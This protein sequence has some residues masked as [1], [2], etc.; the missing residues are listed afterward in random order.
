M[1]ILTDIS[2][3]NQQQWESLVAASPTATW[4]QTY[5]A[6]SF[7]VSL[8]D[9]FTPFIVAVQRNQELGAKNQD[10]L[11]G[12]VVGYVTR[13]RNAVKQF[14][15]RR[16][17]IIGGPLL[18]EDITDAELEALL[19]AVRQIKDKGQKTKD[20]SPIYIEM[21]NFNDYSR[22]KDVFEA[23]G[24]AYQPHLNFHV[25]TS[26]V[27]VMEANL[28]KSRKR[29]LKASEKAGAGVVTNP[30]IE[31]VR[32]FYAILKDLYRTRVR[33]PL[34]PWEFFEKL[35]HLPSAHFLL[36]ERM[37]EIIGGSVGVSLYG[38]ALY[39]WFACGKDGEVKN[40]YPS[41]VTTYSCMCYAVEHGLPRFDMMGAG[42]PEE[43]YGVRDF[44]ARFGGELVEYGRY[45]CVCKPL[46]YKIGKLGVKLLK[47]H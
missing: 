11:V 31:Q 26:S 37:G 14:F 39:D 8:P 47:K 30:T 13:E 22:W 33:T 1:Q 21:R 2:Q 45:L 35:Y 3:I 43:A 34:F 15:T 32:A 6:Y 44:K 36:V 17:I 23:C 25:D 40:V 29:D 9:I 24:F 20:S 46:L 12:V 5:E 16:A 28:H 4:F 38:K 18:A 7:Y 42:K 19:R 10:E 27:E 41:A